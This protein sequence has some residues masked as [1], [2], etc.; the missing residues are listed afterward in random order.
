MTWWQ[1]RL[2]KSVMLSHFVTEAGS[3]LKLTCHCNNIQIDIELPSQVTS[4]NCSICSRYKALWGYY[5]PRDVKI[6]VGD[7][8][9]SFYLW[10]DKELEFVRCSNCGCVTHYRTILGDSEPRIAV[11]FRLADEESIAEIPVRYF[12]GKSQI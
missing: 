7:A 9:E 4:C 8:G 5:D 10:G 12:N 3:P 6:L 2:Q 11:N 1:R